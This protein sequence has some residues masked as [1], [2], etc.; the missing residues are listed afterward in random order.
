MWSDIH[1]D[2]KQ[3]KPR[4]SNRLAYLLFLYTDTLPF[5]WAH[6]KK[7]NDVK[8]EKIEEAIY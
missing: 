5:E 4:F 7:S 1:G 6:K 2:D 3:L 8:P